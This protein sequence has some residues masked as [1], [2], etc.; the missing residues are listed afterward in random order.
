METAICIKTLIIKNKFEVI[1]GNHYPFIIEEY[2]CD[3]NGD[4]SE[5]KIYDSMNRT[6]YMNIDLYVGYMFKNYFLT[7]A[8]WREKQI[9]SIL[10]D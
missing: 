7:L 10:D 6:M 9:D 5:A 1:K 2:S 3:F 4:Y 8:E